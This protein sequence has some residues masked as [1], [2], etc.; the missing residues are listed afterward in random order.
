MNLNNINFILSFG[1]FY[2]LIW[3]IQIFYI[4]RTNAVWN[5][6]QLTLILVMSYFYIVMVDVKFCLCLVLVSLLTF[7]CGCLIEKTRNKWILIFGIS[8]LIAVLAYFKYFNFFISSITHILRMNRVTLNIMLP[9]GISFY[10]F[11]ALSY[12]IDLYKGK[13]SCEKNIL[14]FLLYLSFFPKFTAGPIVRSDYFFTQTRNYKG[15]DYKGLTIGIQIFVF[16]LFKK[17][18]LADHLGVFVSD[19]FRA[20]SAY[21]TSTVILAAI[22]YSLQIY[23]DFSGYSDMAIGIS[24]I[25]GFDLKPNFNL[26]YIAYSMPD[27]WKRWHISLSSWFQDYLYIPLGGSRKGEI[28]TYLNLLAVQLVSGLWHGAG[29]TFVVWGMLHGIINCVNKVI[30]KRIDKLA[31]AIDIVITFIIVTLL[32]VVFRA[33]SFENA[34]QVWRGM[35]TIHTGI[36]Q[37]YVWSYFAIVCLVGATIAAVIHSKKEGCVDAKGNPVVN[38]FYPLLDLSKFGSLVLFFTFCGLT[39]VLG[40]FGNT[41]FIYGA[42]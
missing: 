18:V 14:N 2:I 35:F 11:S 4:T 12:I 39:I 34:L 3:I 36:N 24:R 22:S 31:K 41:A 37:P 6:I 5:R 10:I 33:D 15:I 8:V 28:R 29:W 9:V 7:F 32:W 16:G 23:F 1:L 13:I 27:F 42:F 20:P 19:V 25:L 26:P 17:V 38:G 21:N 30:G 40:Y